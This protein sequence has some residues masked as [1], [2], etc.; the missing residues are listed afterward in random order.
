MND[1][2]KG[3]GGQYRYLMNLCDRGDNAKATYARL[4][5]SSTPVSQPPAGY[6]GMSGDINKDR[7]K[8]FLYIVW[9]T[10]TAQA[11]QYLVSGISVSKFSSTN[12]IYRI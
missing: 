2:A 7:K 8:D 4:L 1:L 9:A 6:T 5:R 3:S 12:P 11:E 10:E